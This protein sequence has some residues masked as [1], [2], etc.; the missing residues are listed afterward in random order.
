M[1]MSLH[2]P[3][4]DLMYRLLLLLTSRASRSALNAATVAARPWQLRGSGQVATVGTVDATESVRP[5]IS[6]SRDAP[7][8]QRDNAQLF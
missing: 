8:Q 1:L 7:V 5:F 3:T 6:N 4:Y 2:G